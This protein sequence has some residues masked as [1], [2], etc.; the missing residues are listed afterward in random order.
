MSKYIAAGK[1]IT[2]INS[3]QLKETYEEAIDDVTEIIHLFPTADVIPLDR[4]KEAR[5]EVEG[6]CRLVSKTNPYEIAINRDA[7]LQIFNKLIAEVEG[8]K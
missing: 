3:I 1:L 2:H 6:L 5:E 4:I 7:V 8:T